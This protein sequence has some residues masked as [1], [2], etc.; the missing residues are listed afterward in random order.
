MPNARQKRISREPAAARANEAPVSLDILL[1]KEREKNELLAEQVKMLKEK[2]L[3]EKQNCLNAE[4]ETGRI[5]ANQRK[6]NCNNFDDC[7]RVTSPRKACK[8]GKLHD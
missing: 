2:L 7:R 8:V 4:F 6:C 5:L 1:K 3:E